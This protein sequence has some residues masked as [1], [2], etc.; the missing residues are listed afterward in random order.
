MIRGNVPHAVECT[1]MLVSAQ[2][3]DTPSANAISTRLAMSTALIRFVNGMIDPHQKGSYA[4]PMQVIARDIGLPVFLVDL[5][6]TCTHETLPS[7]REL[8]AGVEEALKWLLENYWSKQADHVTQTLPQV[9][10]EEV[11]EIFRQWR[12]L[13]RD[14]RDLEALSDLNTTETKIETRFAFLAKQ[15]IKYY[16]SDHVTLFATMVH[17]KV[18][19]SKNQICKSLLMP[20]LKSIPKEIISELF[21]YMFE[22]A[23]RVDSH[24]TEEDELSLVG[25]PL[26]EWLEVFIEEGMLVDAQATMLTCSKT[27]S[28]TTLNVLDAYLMLSNDAKLETIRQTMRDV[29]LSGDARLDTAMQVSDMVKQA[30]EFK[31]RVKQ[32]DMKRAGGFVSVDGEEVEEGGPFKRVRVN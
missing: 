26:S 4:I 13:Y 24:V 29:V 14:N 23:Q 16:E 25:N 22:E 6:H 20:L 11:K 19:I 28:K 12:R 5:R 30:A 18:L 15:L 27:L 17:Q 21:L 31:L 8:R 7:L 9:D 3:E 32:E 10:S 2:I 1:G